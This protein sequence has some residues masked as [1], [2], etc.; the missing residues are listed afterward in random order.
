MVNEQ[1]QKSKHQ[2]AYSRKQVEKAGRIFRKKE[3]D[4]KFNMETR[5]K[6]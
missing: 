4:F 5:K 2:L 3:G 1:Y 6:T